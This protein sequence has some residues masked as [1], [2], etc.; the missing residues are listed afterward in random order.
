MVYND[1]V[2]PAQAGTTNAKHG[3]GVVL[4]P[5]VN[6]DQAIDAGVT[7]PVATDESKLTNR[8]DDTLYY[9]NTLTGNL[10][11]HS[12]AEWIVPNGVTQITVKAFGQGGYGQTATGGNA[13]HGGG[14]GAYAQST[15]S[16]TPG[17]MYSIT[18]NAGAVGGDGG[19]T[20]FRRNGTTTVLLAE[21]GKSG[22]NGGTGGDVVNSI[23]NILYR[24]GNGADPSGFGGGGGGA[25]NDTST[26]NDASNDSQDGAVGGGNGGSGGNGGAQFGGN[27]SDGSPGNNFGGGGGGGSYDIIGAINY[28]GGA[29]GLG[30]LIITW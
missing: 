2:N 12:N 16:V 17:T 28:L 9:K 3:G 29:G 18:L 20:K 19:N 23:G 4:T 22:S 1:V 15:F 24:G 30:R 21:G 13:G 10:E 14:A 5:G 11:F 25:S 27:Q 26:G 7:K 6:V 8:F